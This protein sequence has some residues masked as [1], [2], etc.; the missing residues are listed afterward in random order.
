MSAAETFCRTKVDTFI[1]THGAAPSALIQ[2]L[3]DVQE[4][5]RYLPADALVYV[6]E[7]L[8][9]PLAQTYNVA[10]FYNAFSLNPIGKRH[11]S[12]CMGTACHV[13]GSSMILDNLSTRL[14]LKPGETS[15][16]GEY[17]LDTVNCLGACSLAPVVVIND[18][19]HGKTSSGKAKKL[20]EKSAKKKSAGDK[21]S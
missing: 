21:P 15:A 5:Y 13:R 16:D 8:R 2:V 11:I 10:T 4:E 7:R 19:V 1:E 18:A 3:Q 6:S 12:V 9:V 17:T 20:L 14:N